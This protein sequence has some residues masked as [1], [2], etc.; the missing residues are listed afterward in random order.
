MA[1][2]YSTNLVHLVFSTKGRLPLIKPEWQNELWRNLV[3]IG[4][5]RKIIVAAV[6]GIEDHVH[7]LFFLPSTMTLAK[8]IQEL[9]AN[10]S[11]WMRERDR[12]FSWQQGY[13]AFGVSQSNKQVVIDYIDNQAAHHRKMTFQEEFIALLKK[14]EVA[15]D[16]KWIW[17]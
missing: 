13:G 9:K 10:S 1:H 12:R 17:G 15:Y 2:S 7:I 3:G 6:G 5:N 4:R 11:R 14:H 16:P 8:A